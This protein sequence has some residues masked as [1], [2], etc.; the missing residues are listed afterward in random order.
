[1]GCPLEGEVDQIGQGE[2]GP[3]DVEVASGE[4]PAKDGGDLE[5][6]QFRGGQMFTTESCPGLLA[7]PAVVSQRDGQDARVNDE[8]A[9]TGARS[10]TP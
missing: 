8:H 1:M 10:P 9:R 7:V 3:P 2:L 5:V 6:N 4:L